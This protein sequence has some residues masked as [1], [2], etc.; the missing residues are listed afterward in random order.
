M[1]IATD[2]A[3]AWKYVLKADRELPE[4]QQ[5]VWNMRTLSQRAMMRIVDRLRFDISADEA[6][7]GG[8]GTQSLE[9]VRD[10]LTGWEHLCDTGGQEV[11]AELRGGV[12]SDACLSRVPSMCILELAI[13]IERGGTLQT[14][15]VEKS[16]P[17]PTA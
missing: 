8:I 7:V 14:E 4:E 9:I 1:V 16:E 3:R 2:P 15:D 11:P 13:E 12:L 5:T 10:G 6:T 17:S